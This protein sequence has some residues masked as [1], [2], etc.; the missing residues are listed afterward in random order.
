MRF[1][2]VPWWVV[3]L[4][5]LYLAG[6]PINCIPWRVPPDQLPFWTAFEARFGDPFCAKP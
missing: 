2:N 4:L 3:L 5:L 1:P 6:V